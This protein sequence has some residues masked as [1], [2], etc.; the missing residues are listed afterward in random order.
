MYQQY[1]GKDILGK[2]SDL[3]TRY[4]YSFATGFGGEIC[5]VFRIDAHDNYADDEFDGCASL[6]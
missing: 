4:L 6:E 3:Y 1:Y 2:H 5:E